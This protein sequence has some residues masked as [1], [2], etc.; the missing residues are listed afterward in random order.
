MG[1]HSSHV[2]PSYEKTLGVMQIIKAIFLCECVFFMVNKKMAKRKK[3]TMITIA[4]KDSISL[5]S[6]K[7]VTLKG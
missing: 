2:L 7:S 5:S 6:C 3:K 1:V 4:G